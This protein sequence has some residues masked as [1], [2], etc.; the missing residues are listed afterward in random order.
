MSLDL[1]VLQDALRLPQIRRHD[2]GAVVRRQQRATVREHD[3]VV[4]DVGHL[5]VG[6]DLLRRLVGVLL[7]R[8][9]AADVQELVDPR[10]SHQVL[11][12]LDE[13]FP[14]LDRAATGVRDVLQVGRR[15]FAV[16]GEIVLATEQCVIDARDGRG[17]S[18]ELRRSFRAVGSRHRRSLCVVGN[19]CRHRSAFAYHWQP[20]STLTGVSPSRFNKGRTPA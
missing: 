6:V 14:V 20:G 11:H 5:G 1:L 8:Q 4:V 18:V 17:G 19:R 2:D 13:G 9:A 15:T 16:G 7:G 10:S 12:P 3:R